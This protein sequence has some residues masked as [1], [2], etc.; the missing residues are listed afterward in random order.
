LSEEQKRL[1]VEERIRD[2]A[3]IG[4][5]R[6]GAEYD[7][8]L[9][10][11]QRRGFDWEWR[12]DGTGLNLF[13]RVPGVR[14]H[15]TMKRGTVFNSMSTRYTNATTYNT[16]EPPHTYTKKDGTEATMLPPLYAG[17]E[18]DEP[19]PKVY[20]DKMDELQT[21]LSSNVEW[22]VGDV[23]VLDNMGVQHARWPWTGDRRILASF[24]DV[25]GLK[26][27]PFPPVVRDTMS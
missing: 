16:F 18:E 10:N 7:W 20:L 8:S 17:V 23:L 25:P 6:E 15:P 22:Q 3:R 11:W 12:E 21:A 4:G 2:L 26:A 27:E 9:P 1:G 5:W 13:Q 14:I 24:W 19:I